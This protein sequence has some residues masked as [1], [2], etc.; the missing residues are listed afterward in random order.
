MAAFLW[1]FFYSPYEKILDQD[2]T[3]AEAH[4]GT[5]LAR[6]GIEYVEDP[7][8]QRRIPTCHRIQKTSVF[9]DP[10]YKAAIACA[11][12][13]ETALLYKAEAQQIAQ[14]QKGILEISSREKP[15]D[16]FICYKEEDEDGQRTK[17]SVFAQDIY[18]RLTDEGYRVF[19]SRI[20]LEDKLGEA[21]EPY[22]F[23]AL[24][25]ARVM[26]VIATQPEYMYKS[27]ENKDNFEM[28]GV[29]NEVREILETT[30]FDQF[31]LK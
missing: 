8:T 4:W 18:Y 25:S 21:Y 5:V 20:S 12:D 7:S 15:Y 17:D 9:A 2:D 14:I 23:A 10:D 29:S 3:N 26:L 13:E 6:Y 11:P 1:D 24:N 31:L 16:V 28:T 19:F 30:G 27:L 22:I